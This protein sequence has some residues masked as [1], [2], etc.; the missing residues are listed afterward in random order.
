LWKLPPKGTPDAFPIIA[1]QLGNG[2]IVEKL[3][4]G[5]SFF[6]VRARGEGSKGYAEKGTPTKLGFPQ[7]FGSG[8][9]RLKRRRAKMACKYPMNGLM[10]W[11]A[12]ALVFTF[13][14][15]PSRKTHEPL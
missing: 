3:R 7:K 11:L 5:R 10:T 6:G 2:A 1:Q 8:W 13:P 14:F 9:Q 12:A 15:S 4:S